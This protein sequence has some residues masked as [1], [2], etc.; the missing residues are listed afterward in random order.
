MK[1]ILIVWSFGRKSFENAHSKILSGLADYYRISSVL[2]SGL[3]LSDEEGRRSAGTILYVVL[4]LCG[5]SRLEAGGP[6]MDSR[7]GY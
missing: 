5:W 4:T 6:V 2:L 3:L 7:T 1:G